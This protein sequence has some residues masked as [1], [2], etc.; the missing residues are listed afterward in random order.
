[1]TTPDRTVDTAALPAALSATLDI[2]VTS[3][4]VL[5]DGLNRSV[6]VSTA[7]DAGP[8]VLRQPRKFRETALFTDLRTEYELLRRLGDTP[9]PAPEPVAYHADE[10]LLGDPF[11][12]LTYLDGTVIPLGERLPERF[13]TAAARERL[14]TG[15]VD[16]LAAIHTLDTD[17]FAGLCE[18][19]SPKSQLDAAVDR[20]EA[21]TRATGFE[22]LALWELIDWL[23]GRDGPS[24]TADD[25]LVHGDYRP[26]NV[27]FTGEDEPTLAGVLDW[28]AAFLG[29][30]RTEL[31][32]LLLR[33][34]EKG[35]PPV[36]REPLAAR[37]PTD[38]VASVVPAEGEGL[39]PFTTEPGSSS[40][41]ELV[42]RY[43]TKSGLRFEADRYYRVHAAVLL[44]AVW[45]DLHRERRSDGRESSFPVR[46]DHLSLLAR[47][48][49]EGGRPV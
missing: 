4:E 26:G 40:R 49:I 25:R 44:A 27:L 41:G 21:A 18:R 34:G 23:R 42:A 37:Y 29:D 14:T 9:I 32:Y 15:L 33:W 43:E 46:I 12:V 20:I 45:A 30:P 8:Y 11:V 17:P 35:D 22:P 38:E 28:D 19:R 3:A 1:M 10:S 2:D 6:L 47:R 36:D 7:D 31:G 24:P 48:V 16:T 5:H 13:R 39:S